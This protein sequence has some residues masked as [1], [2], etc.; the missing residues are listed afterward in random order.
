MVTET[1]F[2]GNGPSK[3]EKLVIPELFTPFLSPQF[4]TPHVSFIDLK[5]SNID[6]SSEPRGTTF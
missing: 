4:K 5:W 2:M 1:R 6:T 3:T